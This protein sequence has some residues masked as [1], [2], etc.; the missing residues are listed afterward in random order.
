MSS[1]R[2]S[3][4]FVC[5]AWAVLMAFAIASEAL[6]QRL[7]SLGRSDLVDDPPGIFVF[8]PTVLSAAVVGSIVAVRRPS[9][10]AGWLFLALAIAI[11]AS[12]ALDSYA[13]YG[14]SAR[15][16]SL[17][18]AEFVAQLGGLAFVP[19]LVILGLILLY[20][21]GARLRSRLAYPSAVVLLSGAGLALAAGSIGPYSGSGS[22]PGNIENP[23]EIEA[24]AGPLRALRLTGVIV[25][26]VGLVL[27]LVDL[28]VRFR[29][30]SADERRSLGWLALGLVPFPALVAGAF[31]AAVLNE[32]RVLTFLAA[33][34][35]AVIPIGAGLAIER[36]RLYD[37]DRLL[38]RGLTYS[39]LS[40]LVVGSYAVVVIFVGEALGDFGGDAQ[41]SAVVA[42]LAAV[43]VALPARRWIQDALDRRFNRR[44]F[45]AASLVRRFVRD[46]APG[47]TIEDTQRAALGDPSLRVAYWVEERGAWVSESGE[48]AENGS[49]G[50][51]VE[52]RGTV[53]AQV[54]PGNGLAP[55]AALQPA[56]R[57]AMPELENARLRASIAL[58]LVEVRQ[59]RSRIVAA[60]AAERRRIE[61]NLH[62]GAQQ[63]LLALA[64]QLRAAEVNKDPVRMASAIDDGISQ[65]EIAVRELRELANGL[66]P[67]SLAD[68][69]LSA[70]LDELAARSPI[71]IHLDASAG[72]FRP[73]VEDAAWF[74]ACEAVSNSVKHAAPAAIDI[75]LQPRD[76]VLLLEVADDGV[77]GAD[78]SGDG[79][80]GI[81]DRIEAIGGS[82][83][84]AERTGGGTLVRAELPC[85]S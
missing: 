22:V 77:G 67:A 10:P 28:A 47:T 36:H 59:S 64:L 58:Q 31:A 17:P 3:Q 63:R 81:R 85:E 29:D 76:G 30:G 6:E 40:A 5:L 20:T 52:R 70:A 83:M 75:S 82:L 49:R 60:Q 7:R 23:A 66:R 69:G 26:H 57:E 14:V 24:I 43:S 45:E 78:A 19:W 73:A 65:L 35:V 41:V 71:P 54:V 38:T 15:P 34:F 61:R 50:V 37:L 79:L 2:G 68:G 12:G 9:H 11:P 16:G 27:G 42:T 8:G 74:V 1:V 51:V 84:V 48:A 56:I 32:E 18:A 46:P 25:L 44:Q 62:D 80:R 55:D 72:R 13:A 39:L 21:P 33:G 53:V 4:V